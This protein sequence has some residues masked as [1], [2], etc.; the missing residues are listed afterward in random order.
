[1][2]FLSSMRSLLSIVCLS[3]A[4]LAAPAAHA[5]TY[6]QTKYPI[7]LVHGWLG[8]NSVLA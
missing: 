7:V 3:A 8:F 1:M 4:A 6:A 5:G 2:R